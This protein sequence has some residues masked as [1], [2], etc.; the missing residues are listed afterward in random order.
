M[1]SWFVSVAVV[2]SS[3]CFS[4]RFAAQ[5]VSLATSK[6]RHGFGAVVGPNL[7]PMDLHD[8]GVPEP[9]GSQSLDL[10]L[11]PWG[12]TTQGG[13]DHQ[14]RRRNGMGK[15]STNARSSLSQF[16]LAGDPN[17]RWISEFDSEATLGNDRLGTGGVPGNYPLPSM[18]EWA[19]MINKERDQNKGRGKG[20]VSDEE[21]DH[22][23]GDEPSQQKRNKSRSRTPP[24]SGLASQAGSKLRALISGAWWSP[25]SKPKEGETTEWKLPAPAQ[26]DGRSRRELPV[27]IPAV[28]KQNRKDKLERALA[29]ARFLKEK[30][31]KPP[32]VQFFGAN[33]SKDSK[34]AKKKTVLK[35]LEELSGV[36][37][38]MP[39]DVNLL[40]NLASAL[41]EGGYTAGDGYLIE[42][43]L[44]HIE[45]G[46]AWND[47]LDRCYKQCKRALTRGKGPTKRAPEIPIE[48]RERPAKPPWNKPST[49]VKF[50]VELFGFAMTWMLREIELAAMVTEDLRF[51]H[52]RKRVTVNIKASK[53]DPEAKGVKRTLQCLCDNRGVCEKECPFALSYK[54]VVM[55]EEFNGTGSKL[56]LKLNKEEPSK[57]AVVNTWRHYFGKHLTGH[58]ARRTGA[59]KYIR[60]GWAVSQV[61]HL[62]RWKSSAILLYAEEAMETMP[63]NVVQAVKENVDMA[64]ENNVSLA[65]F[66]EYKNW[67]AKLKEEVK[68]L[69]KTTSAQGAEL[70]KATEMWQNL[71]NQQEG[72]LPSKV[73]SLR[74]KT[75][76][77]NMA[78]I[79]ASPTASWRTLCGWHFYGNNFI[80]DKEIAQVSCQKCLSFCAKQ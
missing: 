25:R 36:G 14:S 51:D 43:K 68:N 49:W 67:T 79:A 30:K 26:R 8:G 59:M 40:L 20:K 56:A 65:E 48:K 47:Q 41:K 53:M 33:S 23:S 72:T 69:K 73:L 75:V 12:T 16:L 38:A 78:R 4:F 21:D 28:G 62:G 71:E 44:L 77:V 45:T 35:I 63:A 58:S 74:T 9:M 80:F 22:G 15:A 46:H 11:P 27:V 24:K 29:C 54:L 37:C 31:P 60:E 7:L 66:E 50:G 10:L 17:E 61:A 2:R 5:D 52:T 70:E 55:V 3:S 13:D 76:H 1:K 34:D 6:R 64:E 19:D 57:Y 18:E 32:I 39:L 42:A